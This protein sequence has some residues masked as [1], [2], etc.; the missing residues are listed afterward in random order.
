MIALYQEYNGKR[1]SYSVLGC[2]TPFEEYRGQTDLNYITFCVHALHYVTTNAEL[3]IHIGGCSSGYQT[4]H[5]WVDKLK[6]ILCDR[7]VLHK[8]TSVLLKGCLHI[9]IQTIGSPF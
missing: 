3:H 7:A 1:V 9:P 4:S 6:C 2:E 8:S 5:L